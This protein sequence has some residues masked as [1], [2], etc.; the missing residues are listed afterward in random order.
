MKVV[1]EGEPNAIQRRAL[2]TLEADGSR[3]EVRIVGWDTGCNGPLVRYVYD[4]LA[5]VYAAITPTGK[6]IT[7]R[8]SPERA[9]A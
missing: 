1:R 5:V 7:G 3:T 6:V 2:L 8:R 9:R 4:G